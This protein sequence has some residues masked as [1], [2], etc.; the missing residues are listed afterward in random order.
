MIAPELLNLLLTAP[1]SQL[2]K[3]MLL[4]IEKWGSTPTAL[5]ILEVVDKCSRYA[6][7][8]GFMMSILNMLLDT[9]I[10]IEGITYNELV[11]QAEWRNATV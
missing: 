6:L 7:A 5:Q 8:S 11:K 1:D 10:Q 9:A 2:D 3:S 4:Y